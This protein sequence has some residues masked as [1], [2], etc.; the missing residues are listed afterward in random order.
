MKYSYAKGYREASTE[1]ECELLR[2]AVGMAEKYSHIIVFAGLTDYVESEGTDRADMRLPKNQLEL[3][4]ALAG[5]NKK[6]TVV[7]Y[8]GAPSELPFENGV[9]AILNMYL[10][11]QNGGEAMRSLLFGEVSPSGRLAESWPVSYSD[12]P[13]GESFGKSKVEAYKESVLVGYRYYLTGGK[14]VRYPFG[15]GLSYTTFSYSDMSV[16]ENDGGYVI[17]CDVENTGSYDG[18]EVV[19]LYV[20]APREKVFSPLRELKGFTKVYLKAGEKKRVEI[21][22][23][24]DALAYFNIKE[25]KY[26]TE[27]GDYRLEIC[28]DCESVRLSHT[29]T[30]SGTECDA[31]YTDEVMDIYEHADLS[32]VTDEVFT[33]M[34][35]I[36]IPSPPPIK[37]I[38]LDSKFSEIKSTFMGTILYKC[39]LSMPKK[40]IRKTKK[41]PEGAARENA[42]KGAVFLERVLDSNSLTTMTMGGG[43]RCPY[44][45]AEG[46][47]H[48]ANGRLIKG[49]LSFIKPIKAPKLPK[50]KDTK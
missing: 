16:S 22:L 26:V 45:F 25:N 15:Y 31:P 18:A 34:S 39:V 19:Q 27:G 12:V 42:I 28:S 17:C 21:T 13:F 40:E 23:S 41:L 32:R 4:T 33:A 9:N 1:T 46:I 48:L 43:N 2:E 38:T 7:L 44:N 24:K 50:E 49:A 36:D 29:L 8:G 6:I 11:G 47:M 5:M 35:G 10:P 30:V 37:P 3:I 20:G 14:E